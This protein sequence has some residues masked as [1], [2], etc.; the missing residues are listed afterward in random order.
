MV[1]QLKGEMSVFKDNNWVCLLSIYFFYKANEIVN[2][3]S[4]YNIY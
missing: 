3:F 2:Y 4:F 1:K